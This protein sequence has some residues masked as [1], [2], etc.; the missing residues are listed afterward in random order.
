MALNFLRSESVTCSGAPPGEPNKPDEPDKPDEPHE[1]DKPD[2]PHKP[3]ERSFPDVA[4]F[5]FEA[6]HQTSYGFTSKS[7]YFSFQDVGPGRRL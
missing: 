2:E 5:H 3:E 6:Y 4:G 7:D 1:P